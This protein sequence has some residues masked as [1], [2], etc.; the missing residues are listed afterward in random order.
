MSH[1]QLSTVLWYSGHRTNSCIPEQRY[2]ESR[3]FGSGQGWVWG[4]Q[5][6]GTF[7]QLLPAQLIHNSATW[8]LPIGTIVTRR[9][10]T[11]GSDRARAICNHVPLGAYVRLAGIIYT[12]A[13]QT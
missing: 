7:S 9:K 1:R 3:D 8:Y 6:S 13:L 4:R 2:R 11:R 12:L 5:Y 10:P